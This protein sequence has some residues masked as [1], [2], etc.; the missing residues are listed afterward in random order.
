MFPP[1]HP[2]Y[3]PPPYIYYFF[4]C[5]AYLHRSRPTQWLTH[6]PCILWKF[7]AA[8]L[9]KV[10]LA[11]VK[12][13]NSCI[14]NQKAF[15]FF[16]NFFFLAWIAG[17]SLLRLWILLGKLGPQMCSGTVSLPLEKT[18]SPVMWSSPSADYQQLK[19]ECQPRDNL[20]HRI[21]LF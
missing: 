15:N 6:I 7:Q 12:M 10:I 17:N 11:W 4:W 2:T 16:F 14:L 8:F 9:T 1:I 19:S 3:S 18:P 5:S 20:V 21:N 13:V